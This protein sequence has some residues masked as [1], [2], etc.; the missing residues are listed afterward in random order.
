VFQGQQAAAAAAAAGNA[1]R[2]EAIVAQTVEGY[3]STALP[4]NIPLEPF[5]TVQTKSGS[6][7][8]SLTQVLEQ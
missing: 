4:A 2:L 3:E 7:Q 1:D 8:R 5:I 6:V